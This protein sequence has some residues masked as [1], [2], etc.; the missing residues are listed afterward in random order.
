LGSKLK[1]QK[2][3]KANAVLRD[4]QTTATA[5]GKAISSQKIP[6]FFSFTFLEA[7][8]DLI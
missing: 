3:S 5:I 1:R 2:D 6:V 4:D 7:T 8:A